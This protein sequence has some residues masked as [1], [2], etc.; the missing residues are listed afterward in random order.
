MKSVEKLDYIDGIKIIACITIFN[1]HFMNFFY[2]GFYSLNPSDFLLGNLEYIVGTTPLNL[3]YGGKFGVKM[4][5]TLSG[6]FV[7]YRY[8]QTKDAKHLASGV[9]KKYFRLVLPIL[10]VNIVIYLLMVFRLFRNE[11]ASVLIGS[12]LFVANYFKATPNLLMAIKEALVDAFFMT[13]NRVYNAPLWFIFYEF[14]GTTLVAAI[15]ALF[16]DKKARY[17][18]YAVASIF[19]LLANMAD[20]LPFILGV[21]VCDFT[22][23]KEVFIE[24]IAKQKWLMWLMFIGGMFLGSFPPLGDRMA[25][26]MYGIFPLKVMLYYSVGTAMVLFSII[27]LEPLKKPLMYPIYRKLNQ[28]SYSFYLVH[29]MILSTFSCYFYL[30]LKDSWNYHVLVIVDY[31]LTILVTLGVSYVL[32]RLVEKPGIK[33]AEKITSY[34]MKS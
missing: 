30:A 34:F 7:G 28:Y 31:I 16:G 21:V 5:M 20:F 2:C 27:H 19:A 17:V 26:T 9:F 24:K 6:F 3:L 1:F 32:N 10:T 14:M 13:G 33:L 12:Q 23:S 15:L 8:F 29:Y 18:V 22:Y 4:F 11:E 25:G